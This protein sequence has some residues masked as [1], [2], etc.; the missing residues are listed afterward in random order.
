MNYFLNHVFHM[1]HEVDFCNRT[2]KHISVSMY[3]PKKKFQDNLMFIIL[4]I[5]ARN[6]E[7]WVKLQLKVRNHRLTFFSQSK[8]N[9]CFQ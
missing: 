7:T 3:L 5:I 6:K 2:L 4:E 8:E 9:F 1:F